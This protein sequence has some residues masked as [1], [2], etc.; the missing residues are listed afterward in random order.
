MVAAVGVRHI[1]SGNWAMLVVFS[2]KV[3]CMHVC[4]THPL[5]VTIGEAL[6]LDQVLELLCLPRLSMAKDTLYLL[7]FLPIDDIRWRLGVIGPMRWSLM[8]QR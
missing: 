5:I 1:Y 7:L 2:D 3:W 8:V 6:P 4:R